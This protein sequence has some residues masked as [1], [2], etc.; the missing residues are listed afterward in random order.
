MPLYRFHDP[1]IT[2]LETRLQSHLKTPLSL[3]ITDNSRSIIYAK[4][5]N[6]Q[7]TVRLH[8]MF[9]GVDKTIIKALAQYISGKHK[10]SNRYL[11]EFIKANDWKIKKPEQSK[12]RNVIIRVQGEHFNLQS[13]F[14]DL[15]K[16]Y[17][18]NQI[19]C[20][21]LWGPPR[22]KAKKKSIRL[23]S[24]SFKTSII[25]INPALDK[26]FVPQYVLDSIVYHEMLHHH[27]GEQERN[28]RHLSH[29]HFF[30]MAEQKFVYYKE[31]KLWI[32]MNL[33]KLLR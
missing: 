22:K 14:Q 27:L 6:H 33:I 7:Y 16:K 11:N 31:A 20:L 2:R 30:K 13:S 12:P 3:I 21:I 17:F 10:N 26:P 8:H 23:G 1:E 32:K 19:D 4:R 9:L 5:Q 18:N 29:H 28:G 24:Y 15:N 25:R